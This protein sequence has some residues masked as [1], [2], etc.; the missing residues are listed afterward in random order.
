MF[1]I[2]ILLNGREVD[3]L[4]QIAHASRARTVAKRMVNKLKE[5]IPPQLF[6]IVIQAKIGAKVI[7]RENIKAT[8]K[9]VLAKCVSVHSC[10]VCSVTDLDGIQ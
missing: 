5:A 9:D 1:Q 8:R 6:E 4:T 10:S 3:E 7:A 2:A